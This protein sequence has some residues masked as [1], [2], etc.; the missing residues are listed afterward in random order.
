[1]SLDNRQYVYAPDKNESRAEYPEIV[2]MIAPN[3]T[4]VDFGCGSG[5]LLQLLKEQKKCEGLGLEISESGVKAAQA[6]GLKAL[7]RAIDREQ[8]DFKDQQFDYAVCNVTLQMVM[9]PEIAMKEMARVAK[10]Q[11][12]SIPNFAHFRNRLDLLLRGRMPQPLLFGYEWWS[13]GHIHQMSFSDFESYCEKN[14]LTILERRLVGTPQAGLK[15]RVVEWRP[16][17]FGVIGIYRLERQK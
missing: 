12:V 3:S 15:R 16:N 9:F 5:E 8:A 10:Q 2:D 7:C 14:G 13:T 6:K 4:V 17:L 1:M 11:I